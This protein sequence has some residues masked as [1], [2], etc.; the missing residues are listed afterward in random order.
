MDF[1]GVYGPQIEKVIEESPVSLI[2]KQL[3]RNAFL[4]NTAYFM[5]LYLKVFEIWENLKKYDINIIFEISKIEESDKD[6][7]DILREKFSTDISEVIKAPNKQS[8]IYKCMLDGQGIHFLLEDKVENK[9]LISESIEKSYENENS[10]V[11]H[12]Y[13]VG[14]DAFI[15]GVTVLSC[16]NTNIYELMRKSTAKE[17]SIEYYEKL[18]K[19]Y[20]ED[21]VKFDKMD[22]FLQKNNGCSSDWQQMV[23]EDP[24]LLV[25]RPE[26]KFQKDLIDYFKIYCSDTVLREVPNLDEDRYD[27]WISSS[28][29]EIYIFEI[30]W[31]GK[32]ITSKGNI[33]SKYNTAKRAVEGAYQLV[34][35]IRK[36][37]QEAVINEKG[38]IKL[39]VLVVFDARQSFE[40]IKY[41]NEVERVLNLDLKQHFKIEP[42]L[43][44][45]SQAMQHLE[46]TL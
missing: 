26:E 36:N 37:E 10:L 15:G 23:K 25:N 44:N 2:G 40:T 24:Y 5:Q 9:L 21:R 16:N 18:L 39:G 34:E 17:L 12:M 14:I 43:Y 7:D 3:E 41:P 1:N 4:I 13:K 27:I 8:I 6:I 38:K 11:F 19:G 22:R 28:I 46:G 20:Y 33:F 30:K 31:L 42:K 32:S 29:N 35:Y 45:A